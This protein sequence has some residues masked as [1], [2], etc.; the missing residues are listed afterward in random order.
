VVS[1]SNTLHRFVPNRSSWHGEVVYNQAEC[2]DC[3]MP[4]THRVHP[5]ADRGALGHRGDDDYM[6]CYNEK[7][8]D[9]PITTNEG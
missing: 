3:R 4:R 6:A 9:K 5:Q 2:G 7:H 8:W 1:K